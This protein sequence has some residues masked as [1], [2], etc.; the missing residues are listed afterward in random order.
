MHDI[1]ES[2]APE[3]VQRLAAC[4]ESLPGISGP[5]VQALDEIVEG[6]NL[7]QHLDDAA[8]HFYLNGFLVW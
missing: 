6:E 3:G 5:S 1:L 7:Q 2:A 8:Q 4:I